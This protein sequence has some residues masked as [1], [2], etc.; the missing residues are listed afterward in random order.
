MG[1]AV[2]AAMWVKKLGRKPTAVELSE[3]NKNWK[4]GG[5]YFPP[6]KSAGSA[7]KATSLIKEGL[8]VE[9]AKKWNR[10]RNRRAN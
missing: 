7:P 6:A 1:K 2:D 10:P 9:P 3:W 4:P 8:S 5:P